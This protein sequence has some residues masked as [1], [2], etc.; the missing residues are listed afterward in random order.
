MPEL[1]H[2]SLIFHIHTNANA[3]SHL[4]VC[5]GLAPVLTHGRIEVQEVN[6]ATQEDTSPFFYAVHCIQRIHFSALNRRQCQCLEQNPAAWID[7]K[8]CHGFPGTG[9]IW[10]C[11]APKWPLGFSC[12]WLPFGTRRL[13]M[14]SGGVTLGSTSCFKAVYSISDLEGTYG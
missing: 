10:H 3:D 14:K 7:L 1:S 8:Q 4:A 2:P 9:P 6:L 12:N 11:R 13:L 5:Q